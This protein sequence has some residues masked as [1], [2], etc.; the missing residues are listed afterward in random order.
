MAG[1]AD[2]RGLATHNP[3]NGKWYSASR[4]PG[5]VNQFIAGNYVSAK[6]PLDSNSIVCPR[7]DAETH[8]YA[9]VCN[10]HVGMKYEIHM[11]VF[12]G[13]FPHYFEVLDA[14]VGI[15]LGLNIFEADYGILTWIPE[16]AGVV[17]FSIKV[18]DQDGGYEI[19]DW[20]VGV[21]TEWVRFVSPTGNNAAAGTFNAPWSTLGYAASNTTG[22]RAICLR[23]GTYNE[24]ISGMSTGYSFFNSIFGFN[25]ETATI[26]GANYVENGSS[27][28]FMC[29]SPDFTIFNLNLTNPPT[30]MPNPRWVDSFTVS[31]RMIMDKCNIDIGGR[32]G[33]VNGDNI[34]C[35]F[36][37]NG[38]GVRN[39]C[40]QTRCNFTNFKGLSNGWSSSDTYATEYFLCE[41]NTFDV[42]NT[43]TTVGAVL[44]VKGT[45]SRYQTIRRNRLLNPWSGYVLDVYLAN[46]SETDNATGDIEICYNKLRGPTTQ[47]TDNIVFSL[48]RSSQ[49]GARAPIWSYRNSIEGNVAIWDRD[50]SFTF[51]SE[52]DVIITNATY[53]SKPAHNILGRDSNTADNVW[54]NPNTRSALT[55]SITGIEC[56]GTTSDNIV[57]SSLELI[58]SNVSYLGTR[59]AQINSGT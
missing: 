7:P 33:T 56:H 35:Y 1:T 10:A 37:G 2:F 17:D 53:T 29:N 58:G 11:G 59:G 52:N 23:G 51:S 15:T 36:L 41:S 54:V 26:S 49:A 34:S 13:A 45:G 46:V 18:T 6:Y 14:P 8:Q 43:P 24:A 22:G 32:Q 47:S 38:G 42:Q 16:A 5:N 28:Y 20:T 31:H 39:H 44:W 27:A 25:G 21:N 3:V 40:S 55:L 12:G 48:G 30:V 19:R 57:N 50:F 4:L 9:Y